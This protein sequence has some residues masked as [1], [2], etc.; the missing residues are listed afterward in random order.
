MIDAASAR[1]A[2]N[3]VQI[4]DAIEARRQVQSKGG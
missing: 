2:R 1:M 3:I 4:A